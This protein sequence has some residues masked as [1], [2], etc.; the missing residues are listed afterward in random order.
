MAKIYTR[1]GDRG[2]TSLVSGGRVAK[3]HP[4]VEAYGTLDEL[5]SMLGLLRCEPLP[6]EADIQLAG[7]QAS[8]FSIGSILADPE[9]RLPRD[10]ER[11]RTETIERWI[12][13]MDAD[14][15]PLAAF[16]LPEGC[17]GAAISHVARTICR[18]AER[19]VQAAADPN[20]PTS[21]LAYL[22]RLSDGLFV[23]ARWL[24]AQLGVAETR[25]TGG[26]GSA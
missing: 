22:N 14:L 10:E 20:V 8:L 4:L 6:G 3:G 21:V 13:A 25:W 12:D 26:A 24:N 16:L 15:E 23:L 18:R 2:E 7:I 9:G 19:R 11:W 5:N 17:R 1:T